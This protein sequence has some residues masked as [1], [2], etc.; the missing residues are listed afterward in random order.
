MPLSAATRG[1]WQTP[2]SD[3]EGRGHTPVSVECPEQ[4]HP[5]T[6]KRL[7]LDRDEGERGRRVLMGAGLSLGPKE[8]SWGQRARGRRVSSLNTLNLYTLKG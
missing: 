6:S 4:A 5:Q 7:A 8:V 2:C 1:P 3:K